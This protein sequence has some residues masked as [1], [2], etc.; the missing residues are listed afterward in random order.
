MRNDIGY[1]AYTSSESDLLQIQLKLQGLKFVVSN[2]ATFNVLACPLPRPHRDFKSERC[3]YRY[4]IT[5]LRR[6]VPTPH[7]EKQRLNTAI[8]HA[9][10]CKLPQQ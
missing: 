1:R 6:C 5:V 4:L 7:F 10:I 8:V 3:S 2:H 9:D